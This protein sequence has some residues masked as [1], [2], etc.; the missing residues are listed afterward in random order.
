MKFSLFV[1]MIRDNPEQSYTKLYEDFIDLCQIAD[2]SNMRAIWTGEHHAMNYAIAPNPFITIAD[3]CR[4]T[5]KIQLGTGTLIVPFWHP[6]KLAGEA[7]MTDVLSNGRLELG[8]ARG[9]YLYEYDR[10]I[11]GMD[12]MEAG[13][14]MREIIPTLQKLWKGDY[15]H[16]GKYFQ[17]PSS[18][19]IP[20]PLQPNG[21]PIWVAARDPNSFEFAIANDWHVQVTPLWKGLEEIERLKNIFNET[22]LKFPNKPKP[23]SMVL[24][25][26]YIGGNDEDIQKGSVAVS[27]F[28][29]NFGAWFKN[30]RA[31]VQGTLDPLTQAELDSN[32]MCSPQEM[33]KNQN[34]G[35]LQD[36][37]DNVKRYEDLGFDEYSIWIDSHLSIEDKKVF[38]DRFISDVMPRFGS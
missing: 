35:S 9:A 18:T 30:D 23:L 8:L 38:L 25:H 11:P 31:V 33:L 6:L 10:I 3:L 4:Y 27:K 16:E 32:A 15:A 20:K 1:H 28:Y 17:F 37:I 26:C 36:V 7:A 2:Q 34:I 14:R 22:Y 29:N 12:A 21:P 5:K 19:S 13:L 24:N